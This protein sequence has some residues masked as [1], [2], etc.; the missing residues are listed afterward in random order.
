MF[1]SPWSE[2]KRKKLYLLL[3]NLLSSVS[4]KLIWN[5]KLFPDLWCSLPQLLTSHTTQSFKWEDETRVGWKQPFWY[6]VQHKQPH[7]L[8]CF[9]LADVFVI[10]IRL[11]AVCLPV[12]LCQ[13]CLSTCLCLSLWAGFIRKVYLTLMIQLLVTVGIICAFLYWWGAIT[14]GNSSLKDRNPWQA[15][16]S[17]PT[18]RVDCQY[19]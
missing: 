6:V 7:L 16:I 19:L 18:C 10:V 8:A 11:S 12:Y 5:C 9:A 14:Q 4:L 2:L 13:S 17:L 3:F 15:S 1:L